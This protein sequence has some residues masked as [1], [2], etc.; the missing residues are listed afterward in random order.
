MFRVNISKFFERIEI[1]F[2]HWYLIEAEHDHEIN[3]ID[4][5]NPRIN[6]ENSAS[7]MTYTLFFSNVNY[8]NNVINK[9]YYNSPSIF[10]P[11]AIEYSN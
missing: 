9:T 6:K 3:D 7:N 1:I 10:K 5:K 11:I 4:D 8:K 2:I